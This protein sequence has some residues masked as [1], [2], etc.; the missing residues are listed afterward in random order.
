MI[1]AGLSLLCA[2]ARGQEDPGDPRAA[3]DSLLVR[4]GDRPGELG[5]TGRRL[6][7]DELLTATGVRGRFGF[8]CVRRGPTIH[9]PESGSGAPESASV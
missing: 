7:A 3:L 6:H 4:E 8:D 2:L 5:P 1:C 9:L